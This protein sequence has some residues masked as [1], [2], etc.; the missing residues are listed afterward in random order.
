MPLLL[1][2][3][4]LVTADDATTVMEIVRKMIVANRQQDYQ[5]TFVYEHAG[6]VDTVRVWHAVRDGIE[7]ERLSYLDGPERQI[8]RNSASA[9]CGTQSREHRPGFDFVERLIEQNLNVYYN[10]YLQD[11]DRIAGKSV[12]VVHLV[13]RDNFRYGFVLAVDKETGLLLQSLLVGPDQR[14][15]ERFQYV[16]VQSGGDLDDSHFLPPGNSRQQAIAAAT[17]CDREVSTVVSSERD[18][19]AAWVPPGFERLQKQVQNRAQPKDFR[20]YSDGMTEFS[21]FVDYQSGDRFP[22]VHARRG[23]TVAY[24]SKLEFP[25]Q[26]VVVCVVGEVPMA[27]AQRV[28]ESIAFLPGNQQ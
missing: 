3:M 4:P 18:W 20:L 6:L 7:F 10:L 12:D 9:D 14:I 24:L 27:T 25:G 11:A 26:T 2:W 19:Q 8:Y 17:R 28:A 21:I 5:G 1:V 23:A 16:D 22:P 15:V 13:P